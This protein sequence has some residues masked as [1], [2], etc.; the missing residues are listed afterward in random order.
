[1]QHYTLGDHVR[2]APDRDRPELFG[3]ITRIE[4]TPRAVV[5]LDT[6]WRSLAYLVIGIDY[7]LGISFKHLQRTV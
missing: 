1:V 5:R 6:P 4:A 2:I 7:P 3:V